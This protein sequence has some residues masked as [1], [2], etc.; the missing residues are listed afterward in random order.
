MAKL[1]PATEWKCC[2][3]ACSM[4]SSVDC[5]GRYCCIVEAPHSTSKQPRMYVLLIVDSINTMNSSL[6]MYYCCT[7]IYYQ[8]CRMWRNSRVPRTT[9]THSIL[10]RTDCHTVVCCG[11]VYHMIST[12][13]FIA[14]RDTWRVYIPGVP[15][16]PCGDAGQRCGEIW[17]LYIQSTHGRIGHCCGSQTTTAIALPC[18]AAY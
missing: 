10:E 1:L 3:L 16:F 7:A 5:C 9:S 11:P 8:A 14:A 15:V 6:L 2:L 13:V 17:V 18:V 12:A 4:Y